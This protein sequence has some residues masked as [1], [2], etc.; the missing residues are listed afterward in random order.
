MLANGRFVIDELRICYIAE[1]SDLKQLN[2]VEIG[3]SVTIGKYTLYRIV[4]DRFGNYFDV[5]ADGQQVGVLKYG[6]YTD[7]DDGIIH[8]YYKVLNP[9]LY[10][11]DLF[12]EVLRFPETMGFV[13]NNFTAIDIA[14]DTPKNLTTLIKK[15]MRNKEI[16][17][18]INGKAIKERNP[19]LREVYFEYSTSLERL[20]YPTITISQKKAMDYKNRGITIQAYNKKA[21]IENNS[22][23]WYILNYHGNP[24]RLYR[25]EV[26]LPY[27]EIKDYFINREIAP[28]PAMIMEQERLEDMFLY[29][30]SSVLR[31]TEGRTKIQWKELL[32]LQRQ[33]IE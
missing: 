11:P 8:V 28:A 13:F 32:N 31:F 24:K 21:E 16:T 33:G 29:H 6:H 25:L 2:E 4:N 26:R 18:I 15:L 23:K 30:L 17:T 10:T 14:F 12:Q 19:I 20:K 22:E 1:V 7:K 3:G 27:Q 9:I 5:S